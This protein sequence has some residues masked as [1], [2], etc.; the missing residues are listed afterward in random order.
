MAARSSAVPT[1]RW[2]CGGPHVRDW[3]HPR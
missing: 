2:G 1:L 3:R